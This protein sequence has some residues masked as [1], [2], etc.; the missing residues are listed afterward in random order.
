MF[1]SEESVD[2]LLSNISDRLLVS[3]FAILTIPDSC[4]IVKK[5]RER[6]VK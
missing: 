2:N 5:V 6:G 3:G 1:E 4:V